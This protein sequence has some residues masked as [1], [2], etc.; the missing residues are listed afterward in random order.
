MPVIYT[1]TSEES[2]NRHASQAGAHGGHNHHYGSEAYISDGEGCEPD[3]EQN[4]EE[5]RVGRKRQVVGILVSLFCRGAFCDIN[6]EVLLGPAIGH[7]DTFAGNWFDTG[8]YIR[9]RIQ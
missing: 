2:G 5:V 4:H 3:A 6:V 8:N 1:Q 9:I 7:H